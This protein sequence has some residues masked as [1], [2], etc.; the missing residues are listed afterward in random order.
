MSINACTN[1]EILWLCDNAESEDDRVE[2]RCEAYS[3]GLL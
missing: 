2:A 1:T 3:R